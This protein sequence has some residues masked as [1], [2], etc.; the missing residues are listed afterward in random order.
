MVSV[1]FSL[2]KLAFFLALS[3]LIVCSM[4]GSQEIKG[5]DKDRRPNRNRLENKAK[6]KNKN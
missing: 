6:N 3:C 2:D 4:S 5:K 1:V